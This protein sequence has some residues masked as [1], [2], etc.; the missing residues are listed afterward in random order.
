MLDK[1]RKKKNNVQKIHFQNVWHVLFLF[2]LCY[3]DSHL[4]SCASRPFFKTKGG[5]HKESYGELS[6]FFSFVF[7]PFFFAEMERL[8]SF[9][10][11]ENHWPSLFLFSSS[12][13]RLSKKSISERC[14]VVRSACCLGVSAHQSSQ[15]FI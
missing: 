2:L 9:N 15:L 5:G 10:A 14:T 7:P 12:V 4:S 1:K 8:S 6:I 3:L 11:R 13:S